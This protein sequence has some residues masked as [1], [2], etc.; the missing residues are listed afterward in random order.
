[1]SKQTKT[2]RLGSATTARGRGRTA[3][4]TAPDNTTPNPREGNVKQERLTEANRAMGRGGGGG[5]RRGDRRDMSATYSGSMKHAAR[6]NTPR[7]DVT[8]R[9]R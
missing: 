6:G 1:M 2:A 4:T 9:K 7:R 5:K 8:T 3:R